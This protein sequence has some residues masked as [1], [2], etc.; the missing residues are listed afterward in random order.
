[1]E[2]LPIG[3]LY[4]AITA[5]IGRLLREMPRNTTLV[6][7]RTGAHGPVDELV[8]AGLAPIGLTITSGANTNWE[9]RNV[10]VPKQCLVTKL[11]SVAQAGDLRVHDE[12]SDWPELRRQLQNFKSLITPS[13]RETWAASRGHDD[14]VIATAMAVWYLEG[15]GAPGANLFELYRRAAGAA[16]ST[17]VLA[18]DFGQSVDPC[19]IAAVARIPAPA[20]DEEKFATVEAGI[21]SEPHAAGNPESEVDDTGYVGS[22]QW[23]RDR[24]TAQKSAVDGASLTGPLRVSFSPTPQAYRFDPQPGSLEWQRL[25]DERRRYQ[26]EINGAVPTPEQAAEHQR[27]TAEIRKENALV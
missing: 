18:V 9:G 6:V 4:P 26:V 20:G 7:D 1:L 24:D 16:P 10:T 2:R 3:T 19:A 15:S 17:Y 8:A 27:R 14:L 22:E 23:F 11:V 12:L 5:R 25:E 21:R 13:G